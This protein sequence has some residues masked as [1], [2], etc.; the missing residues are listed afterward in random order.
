M[1]F[2]GPA[3][4]FP[5]AE[6]RAYTPPDASWEDYARVQRSV[7]LSRFVVVQPSVYGAD[8]RCLVEALERAGGRARGVAGLTARP[9]ARELAVLHETGVRGVRVNVASTG[10]TDLGDIG[11]RIMA[12]ADQA[13]PL[14]WHVQL[15]AE[16]PLL[17]RL[18]PLLEGIMA[19]GISIV[20]D[21]LA[22]ALDPGGQPCAELAWLEEVLHGGKAWVKASAY[23][24]VSRRPPSY[25]D[26]V[27]CARRLIT[28]APERVLW[29]SDWPNTGAHG[30]LIESAGQGT[31]T[32]PFRP[33]DAGTSLNLLADSAP[34]PAVLRRILV[35]NPAALYGF[36]RA[37]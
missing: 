31:P 11:R 1:H 12:A 18:R 29:G 32:I 28:A 6:P 17:A 4:R 21:H 13:G 5:Y 15:H 8:N 37:V 26:A 19:D 23:T 34:E 14:G 2:F 25:E 30:G 22:L 20:L 9:S 24:R 16:L 36:P 3:A 33:I 7:G 27:A 10:D 35:D